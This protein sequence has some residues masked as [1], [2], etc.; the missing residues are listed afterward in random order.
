MYPWLKG[1]GSIKGCPTSVV[2]S[3]SS[4]YPWLKGHGSIKGIRPRG[5]VEF[6]LE[7][8]MAERSWLH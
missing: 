5:D 6:D 7:V 3:S 4:M 1:H 2:A 8:S